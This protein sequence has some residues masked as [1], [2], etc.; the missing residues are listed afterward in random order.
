MRL[1]NPDR[2][3]AILRELLNASNLSPFQAPTKEQADRLNDAQVD[4]Q[5]LFREIT[6]EEF[7]YEETPE[8]AAV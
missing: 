2:A 4:A 5:S 7:E 1:K 8:E 6:G 3:A